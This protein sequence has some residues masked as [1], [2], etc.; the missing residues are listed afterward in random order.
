MVDLDHK[1]DQLFVL[2][3]TQDAKVSHAIAPQSSQVMLEG[4]AKVARTAS[5][6]NTFLKIDAALDRIV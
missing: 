5:H 3:A 1:D 4:F 2:D 6:N